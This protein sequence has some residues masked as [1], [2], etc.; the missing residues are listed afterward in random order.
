MIRTQIQVHAVQ[1]EWLKKHALENGISMSQLIR[2]S[3]D[4]YRSHIEDPRILSSKKEKALKA[5]GIFA[6]NISEADS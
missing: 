2:D 3:I 6:T 1:I 4:F 5:V